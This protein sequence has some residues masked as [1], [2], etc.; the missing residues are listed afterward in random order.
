M[1][2]IFFVFSQGF[3]QELRV[4]T[5]FFEAHQRRI[6]KQGRLAAWREESTF[7]GRRK[8]LKALA[9]GGILVRTREL[10]PLLTSVIAANDPFLSVDLAD[11]I[12]TQGDR[13]SRQTLL[14]KL[15]VP[16]SLGSAAGFEDAGPWL[17]LSK[18]EPGHSPMKPLPDGQS[19]WS[20]PEWLY[21]SRGWVRREMAF[22]RRSH[23][24]GGVIYRGVEF[25][26]GDIVLLSH[27]TPEDGFI[28]S[29]MAPR[30]YA[31]HMG[32]I[33]Q[34][35]VTDRTGTL[36]IPVVFEIFEEGARLVPLFQYVGEGFSRFLEV[37]RLK[38]EN[39]PSGFR[40]G[41]QK[42]IDSALKTRF[43]YDFLSLDFSDADIRSEDLPSSR[44]FATC[45][46]LSDY[47]LRKAGVDLS[48]V[49]RS[50][51]VPGWARNLEKWQNPM[52]QLL[53][54]QNFAESGLFDRVGVVDNDAL[55]DALV[56]EL[57]YGSGTQ[58]GALTNLIATREFNMSALDYPFAL[59]LV[60]VLPTSWAEFLGGLPAGTFPR[61]S[62]EVLRL[63]WMGNAANTASFKGIRSDPGF[64]AAMQ[65]VLGAQ[66][67]SLSDFENSST[68]SAL[69]DRWMATQRSW[70]N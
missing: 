24:T 59:G 56:A 31:S 7:E 41:I 25:Q 46:T 19:D 50:P 66:T 63:L 61:A 11:V 15:R 23:R 54:P 69:R 57:I 20:R 35:E 48:T 49:P 4:E 26:V 3:T 21:D 34:L 39:Q 38:P 67:F 18:S 62:M 5:R 53:T 32:V 55:E 10:Q 28:T 33:H 58:A 2:A 60:S 8:L 16:S 27:Q 9:R 45:A 13:E 65:Q 52:S 70:F 51:V 68:A 14:P 6:E 44:R 42:A 17:V 43:G 40:L 1:W 30:Q 22:Y 47:V 36:T 12:I 64:R 29:V 37:W